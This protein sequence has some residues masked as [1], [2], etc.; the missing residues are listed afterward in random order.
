MEKGMYLIMNTQ[1][2][3]SQ[4]TA[5]HLC[6]M[7]ALQTPWGKS[8]GR[9]AHGNLWNNTEMLPT[10]PNKLVGCFFLLLELA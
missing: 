8:W 5:A 1:D 6:I 4:E 10:A 7:G 3:V 2:K 9:A